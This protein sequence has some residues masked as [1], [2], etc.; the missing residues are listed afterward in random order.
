M[1]KQTKTEPP[2]HKDKIGKV[3]EVGSYVV[4]PQQNHLIIGIVKKLNAKMI[5]VSRL[6]ESNR[7][8]SSTYVNKYPDDCVIVE[9]K[10]VTLLGLSK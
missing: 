2:L 5:G 4:Y 3:I 8:W 1:T 10:Y 6:I 7:S 9:G